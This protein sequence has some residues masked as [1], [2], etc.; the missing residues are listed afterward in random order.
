MIPCHAL[1]GDDWDHRAIRDPLTGDA[2]TADK[3]EA[4]AD[5]GGALAARM[6]GG[7]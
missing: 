6:M 3:P 5:D 1:M 4:A 7:G 2:D